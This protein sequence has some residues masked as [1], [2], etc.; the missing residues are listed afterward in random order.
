MKKYRGLLP[1]AVYAGV[2]VWLAGLRPLW[3]DEVLQLVASTQPDARSVVRWVTYNPGG[4]PLGYLAQR[5]VVLTFGLAPLAARAAPALFGWLSAVALVGFARDL[6][7]RSTALVLAAFLSMPLQLRYAVEGRPYSQALFFSLAALWCLWRLAQAPSSRLAAVYAALVAAGLY[8]QPLS[9]AV[10]LGALVALGSS[11][12]RKGARLGGIALAIACLS[13]AP[14]YLYVRSQ[15]HFGIVASHYSFSM[16]PKILWMLLRE[17]S[18]GGYLA[19]LSLVGAAALGWRR[20]D[21][22]ARRFLLAGVISGIVFAIGA[23]AMS[24]YFFA[25]R[26]VLFVLPALVLLAAAWLPISR[27]E[28]WQS[29]LLAVLLVVSLVKDVKYFRSPGEDWPG[30]ARA[31]L[32]ATSRGTCAVVP[33]PE[34]REM[35]QLFEPG[36]SGRFCNA[37][38]AAGP[39]VAVQ[40]RYTLASSL[41]EVTGVLVARGFR[42][43]SETDISGVRL[44][45]FLPA[46]NGMGCSN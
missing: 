41:K 35:Y 12:R 2:L 1:L 27:R 16:A 30:A 19:S 26:Q 24:G 4:A 40:D 11:G 28:W 5:A 20:A 37:S 33:S 42:A 10:Q 3:L 15:W 9:A 34:P 31:L 25:V 43:V 23:D 32:A 39:A 14:W 29:S 22:L 8:T 6:K 21:S 18:G 38:D 17:I 44:L 45:L 46:D 13:F 36:L 7:A